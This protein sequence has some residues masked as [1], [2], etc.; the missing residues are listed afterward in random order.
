VAGG[1]MAVPKKKTSVSRKG[2]RRAGQHH[3]LYTTTVVTSKDTGEICLP[4]RVSPSG[5]YKGIKVF[6]T[7][8]DKNKTEE[9]AQ[10]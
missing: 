1:F 2:K 7:R 9:A 10:A 3:K 8:A 4:H 5:W 6:E